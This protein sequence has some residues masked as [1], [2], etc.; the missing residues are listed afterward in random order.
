MI[1]TDLDKPITA[2]EARQIALRNKEDS[3]ER[4]LFREIMEGIRERASWGMTRYVSRKIVR[5]YNIE[6][7]TQAIQSVGFRVVVKRAMSWDEI[8][9]KFFE[10]RPELN[11]D[12]REQFF[13]EVYWG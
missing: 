12:G 11:C 5:I 9:K 3:L 2:D 6:Q 13:I 10:D 1:I 8:N 7:I 4:N